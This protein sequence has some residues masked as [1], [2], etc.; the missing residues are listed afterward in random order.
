MFSLKII[1][2]PR[3][4]E[5]GL[6]TGTTNAYGTALPIHSKLRNRLEHSTTEKLIYVYSTSKMVPATRDANELKVLAW[7]VQHMKMH[8]C[9]DRE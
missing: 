9:N 8:S 4:S 2:L 7:A 3:V 1:L 6:L 5:I